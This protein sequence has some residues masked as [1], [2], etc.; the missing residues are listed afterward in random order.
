MFL[1]AIKTVLELWSP[2]GP[3][4]FCHFPKSDTFVNPGLPLPYV[5]YPVVPASFRVIRLL[6]QTSIVCATRSTEK[7]IQF[8]NAWHDF[9]CGKVCQTSDTLSATVV[10]S[11]RRATP[12][13][14]ASSYHHGPRHVMVTPPLIVLPP[15]RVT[16]MMTSRRTLCWSISRK[17]CDNL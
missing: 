9:K 2:E 14:R 10:H 7:R 12:E 4:I 17:P 16:S 3:L 11:R 5:I 1:L 13:P 6:P 15:R 8:L